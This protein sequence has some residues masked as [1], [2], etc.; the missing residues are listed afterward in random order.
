[1]R[2]Q[3]KLMYILAIG[4][5]TVSPLAH[6]AN[7]QV[8]VRTFA[9]DLPSGVPFVSNIDGSPATGSTVASRTLTT[10]AG[11]SSAHAEAKADALGG[12][13]GEKATAG[14]LASNFVIGRNAGATAGA[15]MEGSINLAGPA[16]PGLATF[17][18]LL[19]GS[20]N[21]AGQQTFDNRAEF[22]YEFFVGNSPQMAGDLFYPCCVSGIFNI[23]FTWTQLVNPGDAIYFSLLLNS[24]VFSVAGL[25]ELDASNTFKITGIELPQGYTFTSDAQGFLSQFDSSVTAVPEPASWLLICL[26]LTLVA[27]ARRR[28]I[29]SVAAR[30][31][32]LSDLL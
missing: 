4:V 19:D 6:A 31:A 32:R 16:V 14:V 20:Y 26:G 27:A 25:S 24:S 28:R 15:F 3:N 11:N 10:V 12:V 8:G 5:Y 29:P 1:M 23:P 9:S 30:R 18:A 7:A 22:H 2:W 17:T 21:V 13:I